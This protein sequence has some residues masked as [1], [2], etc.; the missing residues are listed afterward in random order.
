MAAQDLAQCSM[1]EVGGGVVSG[2]VQTTLR[3]HLS[4]NLIAD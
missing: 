1:E 3:I 2:D 4:L